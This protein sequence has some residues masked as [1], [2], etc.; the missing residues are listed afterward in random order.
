MRG[1]AVLPLLLPALAQGAALLQQFCAGGRIELDVAGNEYAG[2]AQ[3][4][5]ALGVML[6]LGIGCAKAAVNPLRQAGQALPLAQGFFTQAGIDQCHG[7][8][9][10]VAGGQQL[11]PDFRFHD[12]ADTGAK[13]AQKALHGAA[14]VPRQ[15]DLHIAGLQQFLP[16]LPAGGRAVREQ[17][18]QLRLRLAQSL[19]HDACR[20]RFAQR[21]G[22][23][24]QP[25]SGVLLRLRLLVRGVAGKALVRGVQ[26]QRL[27]H[28]AP[29]QLAFEQGLCQPKEQVVEAE[30]HVCAIELLWQWRGGL[31][32]VALRIAYL[33][34][35]MLR[36][37]DAFQLRNACARTG[38]V[39]PGGHVA[40]RHVHAAQAD[41]ACAVSAF[42]QRDVG[43][44]A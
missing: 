19:Q 34:K 26:V 33:L 17:Q 22:V 24:P 43:Q 7:Y 14:C 29:A 1:R 27:C 42:F 25:L 35:D 41:G 3:C 8:A 23:N 20:A 18:A 11:R 32:N 4:A 30:H 21:Y 9:L 38:P 10:R 16:F 36:V 44:C 5:Q 15:P 31:G 37:G 12:Q 6:C 13:G 39:A 2:S 40:E 28:A